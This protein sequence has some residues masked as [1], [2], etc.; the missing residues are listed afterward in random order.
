MDGWMDVWMDRYCMPCVAFGQSCPD[1]TCCCC[2]VCCGPVT[3]QWCRDLFRQHPRKLMVAPDLPDAVTDDLLRVFREA[4]G[5]AHG[6]I[7]L[8]RRIELLPAAPAADQ[9]I[10]PALQVMA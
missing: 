10:T 8:Q 3:D 1:Q 9:W 7:A 4:G 6:I 5:G 2:F